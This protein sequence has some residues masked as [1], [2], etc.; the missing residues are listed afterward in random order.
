MVRIESPSSI[1]TFKQ[2]KR[3]YYHSYIEKLPRKES[4]EIIA[5]KI[6]HA[7]IESFHKIDPVLINEKH[8][9]R[10]IQDKVLELFINE[11]LKAIP[12]LKKLEEENGRIQ[13]YYNEC[14]QMLHSF[15]QFSVV[16]LQKVM[17]ASLSFEQAFNKLK[18]KTEVFF[19]SE[20]HNVRGY[21]DAIHE[22]ENGEVIIIDYK[23][24][25]RDHLSDE[26]KLQ[27]AIYALM[28]GEKQGR[29]P[30]QVGLHFLRQGTRINLDV[31]QDLVKQ[32]EREC[33]A[34]KEFT[35]QFH[36]KEFYPMNPGPLCKWKTGQ[37]D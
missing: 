9:H 18:P 37:C 17:N 1:N 24:S 8:I 27:L 15:V 30:K 31:N 22:D 2:C 6:V 33:L 23:T 36:T 14:I 3:K 25:K 20:K 12:S 4:I 7:T 10:D 34:I 32:A 5:G 35:Q 16:E 21:I 19:I 26:Y 28:V 29:L 13:Q 11:W